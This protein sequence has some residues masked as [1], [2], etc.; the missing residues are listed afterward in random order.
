MAGL[1]AIDDL[2][3]HRF[4]SFSLRLLVLASVHFVLLLWLHWV[5]LPLQYCLHIQ[6][7]SVSYG[8]QTHYSYICRHCSMLEEGSFRGRTADFV[9]MFLFGAVF[10]VLSQ[11]INQSISDYSSSSSLRSFVPVSYIL[12]SLAMH[13]QLWFV[14]YS[15][16]LAIYFCFQLVYVWS[17][18]NP[19]VG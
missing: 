10:M 3:S 7:S 4:I 9:F 5:F 8:G 17:R 1:L 11:L 14:G 13:S 15:F 18:R 19:F 2:W 16:I 12:F 6:V